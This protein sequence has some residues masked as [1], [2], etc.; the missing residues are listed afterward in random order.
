MKISHI[1]NFIII[2]ASLI[3]A[4][5]FSPASAFACS[6]GGLQHP[7]NFSPDSAAIGIKEAQRLIQWHQ[8]K[9]DNLGAV[10]Y[11]YVYASYLN[12]SNKAKALTKERLNNII[13]L[14][15]SMKSGEARIESAI[16]PVKDSHTGNQ[17]DVGIQPECMTTGSCCMQPLSSN[18]RQQMP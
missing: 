3:A 14:L 10:S 8:E 15:K 7:V 16:N 11:I 4:V 17:I 13:R 1:R 9:Y 5:C 12:G 6:I 2:L 18:D